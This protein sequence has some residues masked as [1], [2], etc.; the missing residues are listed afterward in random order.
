MSDR[1]NNELNKLI[2]YHFSREHNDNWEKII[3]EFKPNNT[4]HSNHIKQA[5]KDLDKYKY[6]YVSI[7][8]EDYFPKKYDTTKDLPFGLYISG[9]KEDLKNID[10][11]HSISIFGKVNI[12]ELKNLS[13]NNENIIFIFNEI[14]DELFDEMMIQGI[15]F[16]IVCKNSFE[17]Y[18]NEELIKKINNN[19]SL[20]ISEFKNDISKENIN[21]EIQNT[22]RL[23]VG[24][25]DELYIN[26]QDFNLK[27]VYNARLIIN[28]ADYQNKKVYL[29][30]EYKLSDDEK[31]ILGLNKID[32]QDI[33]IRDENHQ[34]NKNNMIL[35]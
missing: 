29:K 9:N 21:F 31:D 12:N 4:I 34:K 32:L 2:A 25:S 10:N 8:D 20:L 13:K 35:N 28:L 23:S 6:N 30:N 7:F 19:G 18:F 22:E 1:K 5:K 15:P 17:S 24:L 16:V 26:T 14:N 11:I 33:L 27:D 3:N